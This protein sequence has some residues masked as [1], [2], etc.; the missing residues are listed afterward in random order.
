MSELLSGIRV[1]KMFAWE[2]PA[3]QR[4]HALRALEVPRK[5]LPLSTMGG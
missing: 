1:L 3:S 4:V 5:S 2:G